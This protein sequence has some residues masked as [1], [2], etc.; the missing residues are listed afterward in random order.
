VAAGEGYGPDGDDIL[1]PFAVTAAT[2][3]QNPI[4]YASPELER[5]FVVS[6][7]IHV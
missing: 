2:E 5:Q 7:E 4:E 3:D 6:G 1:T